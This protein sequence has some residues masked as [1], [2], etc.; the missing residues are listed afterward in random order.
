[1][2]ELYTKGQRNGGFNFK[3]YL[4]WMFM[5]SC[6]MVIIFFCMLG[7]YAQAIFTNDQS[8]Y[9]LG[10]LTYTAV[11]ILISFKL[12]GLEMHS[13]T[14]TAAFSFI[15]SVGGWFLWCIILASTYKNTSIYYV[16]DGLWDAKRFGRNALWWLTLIMILAC[17]VVFEIGVKTA[18][19]A[20]WTTDVDRFQELEKD[21][22]IKTRFEDAATLE[23]AQGWERF[24]KEGEAVPERKKKKKRF[25]SSKK[26]RKWDW[27]G[28]VERD[29]DESD[30]EEAELEVVSSLTAQEANRIR[31]MRT[32]EEE[33]RR[34][35]EVRDLLRNRPDEL[36]GQE[37]SEREQVDLEQG[38]KKP[39]ASLEI[40]E[41]LAR[42]FGGV[43]RSE[44][45]K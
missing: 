24:G 4:G 26:G 29:D 39:R 43:K 33:E 40:Q 30:V 20:F 8:I 21:P 27:F 41:M 34:E 5:A 17:V 25:S 44:T 1:M 3:I 6:E 42:G 18:R 32:V 45:L 22:A 9:A 15:C 35:G 14:A 2:P 36:E 10:T 19:A 12:Q 7:L 37:G 31:K 11:V 16:K 28:L 38:R 13:K 23:L